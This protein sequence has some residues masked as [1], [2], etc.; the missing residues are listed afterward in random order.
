MTYF[1][2][3]NTEKEISNKKI[4]DAETIMMV[5]YTKEREVALQDQKLTS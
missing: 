4:I 5:G 2:F 3:L 1:S